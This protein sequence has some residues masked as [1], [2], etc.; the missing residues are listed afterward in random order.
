L[1]IPPFLHGLPALA[2]P[3]LPGVVA[4]GPRRAADG[5]PLLYLTFDDGPAEDTPALLGHLAAHGAPALFFFLGER[6]A[7]HPEVVRAAVGAGHRVGA[8]GW[9]HAD[10][11]RTPG[12]ELLAG[13]ERAC[14]LMEDLTGVSVR[15]VR[16]PYGHLTPALRR[17]GRAT[18]RRVV[19]WDL[20]PGD[21]VASASPDVVARRVVRKARPGSVVV[22][23]EGAAVRGIAAD[24]LGLSLPALRARGFRPAAL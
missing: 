20:M 16:P 4:R 2:G 3:L 8:H 1:P 13:F 10:P 23:H 6:A 21:F 24:A 5:A 17:W 9:T 12:A 7:R 14:A 19:L 22:L 18:G 15:D 11:W